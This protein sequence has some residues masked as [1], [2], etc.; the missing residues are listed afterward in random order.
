MYLVAEHYRGIRIG[1]MRLVSTIGAVLQRLDEMRNDSGYYR[2]RPMET[3]LQNGWGYRVYWFEHPEA[4]P[5]LIRSKKLL[6]EY[7]KI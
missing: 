5:K 4:A 2:S 1:S 3:Y 7:E 6:E